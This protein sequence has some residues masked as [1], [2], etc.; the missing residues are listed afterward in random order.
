MSSN[1]T[2]I[3]NAIN[4]LSLNFTPINTTDILT[5]AI[6][7]NNAQTGGWTGIILFLMMS[8]SV[9]IFIWFHKSSFG[10]FDKLQLIFMSGK[11]ILDIGLYLLVWNILNNV[12]MYVFILTSFFLI[13]FASLIKK[14]LL[15]TET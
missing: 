9:F 6:N 12:Y 1:I 11:V 4:N 2:E 14:E 8:A 15:D 5:T 10:I 3:G 7:Y 13:G